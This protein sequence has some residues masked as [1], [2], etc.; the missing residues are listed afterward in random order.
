MSWATRTARTTRPSGARRRARPSLARLDTT[1]QDYT[2]AIDAW[3]GAVEKEAGNRLAEVSSEAV[4]LARDVV[5]LPGELSSDA[6]AV[7]VTLRFPA[8]YGALLRAGML[9]NRASVSWLDGR[10]LRFAFVEG[11]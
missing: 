11:P 10:A 8:A 5:A 3:A 6:D 1:R 4:D 7:R 9:Q 2:E